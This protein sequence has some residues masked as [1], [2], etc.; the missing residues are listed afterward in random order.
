MQ[1]HIF[2]TPPGFCALLFK[3]NPTRPVKLLLPVPDK[4]SLTGQIPPGAIETSTPPKEILKI[5]AAVRAYF[6]GEPIQIHFDDLPLDAC[7][8]LQRHVLRAVYEIPFG[9]TRSYGDIAKAVQRPKAA[10][11]V[12][13]TMAN[14]PFPLLI[15]CHRVIKSDGA[16]GMFGGGEDLKARL[17]QHEK[18]VAMKRNK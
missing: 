3:T 17:L 4:A 14:N 10:R 16:I 9:Q 1:Y 15:P 2:S 6:K 8:P 18:T 7:T 5:T 13:T 12:G 11:F